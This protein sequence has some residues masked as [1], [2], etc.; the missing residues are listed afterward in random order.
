MW[1]IKKHNKELEKE[2]L[3]N[4]INKLL[5]RLISQRNINDVNINDFI[6][7]D[8]E[9]LPDPYA[10]N[11]VE[12]AVEIFCNTFKTKVVFLFLETMMLTE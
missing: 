7:C 2:L 5:A 10:L 11:G 6:N 8:Y 12:K 4:N 3:N 1:E 9:K